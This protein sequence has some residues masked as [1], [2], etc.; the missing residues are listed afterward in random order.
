MSPNKFSL[1]IAGLPLV[2]LLCSASPIICCLLHEKTT[3]LQFLHG[4][5]Q[6]GGLNVS[7]RN[8]TNCCTWEGITCS[9]DGVVTDVSLPSRNLEGNIS[10]CLGHLTRLLRL[11]LS[12]NLLSGNLP[13]ELLSSSSIIVLDVSSNRLTG[14]LK[15][16]PYTTSVP[17]LQVLNIS[18]NLFT[19]PFPRTT[20]KNLLVLNASNNSFTGH[21]PTQLCTSS[22]SLTVLQ[23]SYNQLSGSIPPGLGSCSMLRVLKVGHNNLSGTLPT[24]LFNAITLEF[25]SLPMNGLQGTLQSAHIV[26]LSSLISLDLGGNSFS[27][28]I[29]ES[30]GHLKRLEELHL[31]N[32]MMYGELPPTLTNCTNLMTIN[33]QTNNFSGEL[34]KVNFSNL[35]NLKIMDLMWNT[36]SGTIPRSIY[37]CRNLIALRLSSNKFHGQLPEGIGNLK[38]LTFLSL[39]NNSLTNIP[40][41]LQLLGS[42]KNLITLLIGKYFRQETMP[43]DESIGGFE[44]VQILS[45]DG[46]S[47]SGKIPH[48]LSKLTNLG[49]LMLHGNRLT[50]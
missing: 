7:W 16:L 31:N 47:L 15:E 11:N 37:S 2:L 49:V 4:L 50:G 5:S 25:L 20:W 12:S 18:S 23:L 21:L 1:S 41:A 22:P 40:N 9:M 24:E 42:S 17:P 39:G 36:F 34:T 30:I 45:L 46:C 33:L 43:E 10:S 6:E 32:N 35:P 8:D 14:G 19:G 38:S 26:K 29:P 44:N 28:I 27:G 13:Q 48:W 3:L